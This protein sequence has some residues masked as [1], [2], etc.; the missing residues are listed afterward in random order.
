M[1]GLNGLIPLQRRRETAHARPVAVKPPSDDAALIREEQRMRDTWTKISPAAAA[2]SLP[3]EGRS[4]HAPSGPPHQPPFPALAGPP[5]PPPPSRRPRQH[6]PPPP[7][8]PGPAPLTPRRARVTIREI[9]APPPAARDPDRRLPHPCPRRDRAGA[10]DRRTPGHLLAA[11]TSPPGRH[12]A[13]GSLHEA[14][15]PASQACNRAGRCGEQTTVGTGTGDR[16]VDLLAGVLG[17]EII[18]VGPV[19]SRC[20]S[21]AT[22]PAATRASSATARPEA[23]CATGAGRPH[24]CP[25]GS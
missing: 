5:R 20:P 9:P 15:S 22:A 19:D 18:A 4:E 25:P 3:K 7:A 1:P 17:A 13:P 2:P 16:A 10:R 21:P 24:S 14:R 12:A 8:D 23:R 6:A 11:L